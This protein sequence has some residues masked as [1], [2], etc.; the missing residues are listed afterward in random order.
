MQTYRH[1]HHT[2]PYMRLRICT[3]RWLTPLAFSYAQLAK[4]P[5][6]ENETTF[7]QTYARELQEAEE[8]CKRYVHNQNEDELNQAWDVYY[9]VFKKIGKQLP[10]IT[11]LELGHCSPALLTAAD[12]QLAVPGA[13]FPLPLIL[14]L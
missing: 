6:T 14:L 7:Y 12:L 2:Q 4:G 10:S 1:T 9:N 3:L 13:R 11:S 5:R 8:C